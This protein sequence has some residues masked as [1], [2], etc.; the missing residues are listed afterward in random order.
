MAQARS[1]TSDYNPLVTSNT[2][3]PSPAKQRIAAILFFLLALLCLF[4]IGSVVNSDHF[5]TRGLPIGLP[6]PVD[7]GGAQIGINVELEKYGAELPDVLREIRSNGINY[8]KQPFYFNETFDWNESDRLISAVTAEG[9]ELIPLL[10]G[11]PRTGFA[12]PDNIKA[13]A[14]WTGEFADRYREYLTHYI[15]WDEPNLSSHWGSQPVNPTHYAA[16]LSAAAEAVRTADGNAVIVAG[17]LAP[18]TETGPDNLAEPLYLQALYEAGAASSF[19]VVAAK[20]YGFDTGPDDRS[21]SLDRLNFS[22]P[23]L[24]RELMEK[25]G[26]GH[27]AIWAGNWGWNS[28]PLGWTGQPSIWGQTSEEIQADWTIAALERAQREW[29]WMGLLFLENWEPD[30]TDDDPRWGFSIAGRPTADA[31][32]EYLAA[33]PPEVALPGF[34]LAN[35]DDPSQ[36]YEGEWEFSPEFG[37]DIGQ[38]GDRVRFTFWGTDV[39]LRVRR[40]D[41]RARLYAT[42]DGQPANALPQDENGATLVLTSPDPTQDYISTEWVARNLSPGPHTL[43]IVAERGWDQWAL[44]GFSVGYQPAAVSDPRLV[45][46]LIGLALLFGT[47]AV[48]ASRSA[49]WGAVGAAA[50]R[51]FN[52]L[53]DRAQLLLTSGAGALVVLTGWMTWG[54]DALGVYRRLGDA[55]Q[56]AAAAAAATVFYVSPSFIIFTA[57]LALLF[58][59]LVLRPAWGIALI[60]L[61][62]PFYVPPLPKPILGYRFSPVEIFTL[63]TTAAWLLRSFLDMGLAA[64]RDSLQ[65]NWPRLRRPDWAVVTFLVVATLSLGVAEFRGVALTEWRVLIIEPVLFYVLL[66]AVRLRDSEMWVILDAFVLSGLAVALYGLWQYVT[67]QNL[68]TA[69]GGLLRLRSIYGS[70]NNVALYLDRLLPL[71]I[72]MWLLGT[73]AIHGRRHLLYT[74]AAIPVGAA[75]VLTFS[76]G[77]LFLGIPVSLAII[78]WIWQRRAGRRTWPWVAAVAA[79]GIAA[80]FMAARIPALAA[81]L[82]LFGTTGFFRINLWRAA[83]NMV[84][85]HPW[86]GVGLDNFLYAYRGRYILDAAW[87]EPNLNHPHNIILD[88]ATRL[89]VIGLLAGAW[90][91]GETAKALGKA[92]KHADGQWLPVAAG[93]G[94]SLAAMLAHGLVDH[95]LFL[96]D[97]SFVFFLMLGTAIRINQRQPT[98]N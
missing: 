18:T 16:L 26:D 93:F 34:H 54:Q 1:P 2:G 57:A 17:P 20:P 88:F 32:S 47:L 4:G 29:P 28:L 70:P 37:A 6:E 61:T 69:E 80:L 71:L 50:H 83:L 23:I 21:V 84:A 19:D 3:S 95:S 12:P 7:G 82:D 63:V 39:G 91:I 30:A 58:C 60:T 44:N 77:A 66:R 9:M 51:A 15:V 35:P 56:L 79:I 52:G 81:R 72:G 86:L 94:G 40:A 8:V 43:E 78:F 85:D 27:K 46:L 53:S 13:F 49:Q 96:I 75:L 11:D 73:R 59:L 45:P 38:S 24:L 98:E 67:G 25:N 90:L 5:M 92:I 14:E 62:I 64:R 97:L 74:I 31:L 48:Y 10:D 22:R 68:I 42:I 33:Q 89:G 36:E 55:G 76:K 65:F 41:F 87:Q